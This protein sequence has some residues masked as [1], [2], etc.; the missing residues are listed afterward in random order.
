[1]TE[2]IDEKE[3]LLLEAMSVDDTLSSEPVSAG[4]PLPE[5]SKVATKEQIIEAI[6][7]VSDPEIPLNVYDMGLIYDIRQE[8]NGD[9]TI[10]MTL[11]APTCPVAGILP[12]QVAQ[13]VSQVEGTGKVTVRLVFEPQ[14]TIERL[15]DEAKAALD[16]F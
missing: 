7:E 12:M 3:A 14:W 9:I 5:G 13:A 11:T 1:M 10:D 8:T 6:R 15:T 4:T 2:E 16:L